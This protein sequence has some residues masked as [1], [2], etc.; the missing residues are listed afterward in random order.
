MILAEPLG[1]YYLVDNFL[2]YQCLTEAMSVARFWFCVYETQKNYRDNKENTR[3]YFR[4]SS[5]YP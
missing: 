4:P 3:S 5:Y 1:H 2:S